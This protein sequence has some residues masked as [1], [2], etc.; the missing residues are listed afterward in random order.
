MAPPD[1]PVTT[2][3]SPL[4]PVPLPTEP[5]AI[6]TSPVLPVALTPEE[7]DTAPVLEAPTPTDTAAEAIVTSPV[8]ADAAFALVVPD[9]IVTVPPLLDRVLPAE[10]VNAAPAWLLDPADKITDPAFPFSE[11]PV[12]ITTL[13][14][15]ESVAD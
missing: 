1:A 15:L 11:L 3:I 12:V 4:T 8:S 9:V 7:K 5:D 13:P 6:V 10:I 2:R 14:V